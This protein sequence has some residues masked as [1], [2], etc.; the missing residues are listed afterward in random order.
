M[1]KFNKHLISV[2]SR[3]KLR[4]YPNSWNKYNTP[5][6]LIDTFKYHFSILKIKENFE[7]L[8]KITF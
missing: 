8:D 5:D 4:H 1:K 2:E 7:F 3:L 6:E